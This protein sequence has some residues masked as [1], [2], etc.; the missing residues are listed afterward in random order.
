VTTCSALANPHRFR[1]SLFV[2]LS[3]MCAACCFNPTQYPLVVGTT[4]HAIVPWPSFFHSLGFNI[5]R[6]PLPPDI[7]R[8]LGPASCRHSQ[9]ARAS[10]GARATVVRTFLFSTT[11]SPRTGVLVMIKGQKVQI[12]VKVNGR[13]AVKHQIPLSPPFCG[14]H[15]RA[16]TL[17]GE[18]VFPPLTLPSAQSDSQREP[19]SGSAIWIHGNDNNRT[20]T[21]ASSL[22]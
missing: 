3:W 8:G 19:T 1:V 10:A 15:Q 2:V 17:N 22:L 18:V 14:R 20:F 12:L 5:R 6:S 16:V 13:M 21:D 7:T 4:A 9:A 11:R